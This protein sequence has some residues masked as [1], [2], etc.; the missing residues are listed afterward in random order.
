M[1]TPHLS[2]EDRNRCPYKE[3]N[4]DTRGELK[5][6]LQS[7]VREEAPDQPL[8]AS[9]NSL[10]ASNSSSIVYPAAYCTIVWTDSTLRR[11]VKPHVW[12][13]EQRPGAILS[14]HHAAFNSTRRRNGTLAAVV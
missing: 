8:A 14:R 12:H 1:V 5:L 13:S 4:L 6:S 9:D 10:A 7:S 11:G 2:W 3:Q